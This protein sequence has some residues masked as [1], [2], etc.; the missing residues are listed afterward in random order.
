MPWPPPSFTASPPLERPQTCFNHQHAILSCQNPHQGPRRARQLCD[1]QPITQP[2]TPVRNQPRHPQS[3]NCCMTQ[4]CSQP[5]APETVLRITSSF[6][7]SLPRPPFLTESFTQ[8][9]PATSTSIMRSLPRFAFDA[10]FRA[11][12]TPSAFIRTLTAFDQ[13]QVS[14]S[15]APSQRSCSR[16]RYLSFTPRSFSSACQVTAARTLR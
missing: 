3:V 16:A 13:G 10:L 7:S 1:R 11:V 15:A 4:L 9:R 8:F 12:L 6:T 14:E 5:I 2:I